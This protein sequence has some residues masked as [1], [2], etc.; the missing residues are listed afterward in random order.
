MR[1]TPRAIFGFFQSDLLFL[2][3]SRH[4]FL[5]PSRHQDSRRR[6]SAVISC[7]KVDVVEQSRLPKALHRPQTHTDRDTQTPCHPPTGSF[8]SAS[9]QTQPRGGKEEAS[10]Y[11]PRLIIF[12]NLA[13]SRMSCPLAGYPIRTDRRGSEGRKGNPGQHRSPTPP[14]KKKSRI[15]RG[16]MMCCQE[17]M[18]VASSDIPIVHFVRYRQMPF[19]SECLLDPDRLCDPNRRLSL[20][21]PTHP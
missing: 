20:K 12:L 2:N 17:Y 14:R 11:I 19:L 18:R 16:C 9:V 7:H 13:C 21:A 6:G 10:E 1:I 8:R 4:C 15:K 3:S 5:P